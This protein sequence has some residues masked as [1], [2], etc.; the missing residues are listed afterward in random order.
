MISTIP[1]H[2]LDVINERDLELQVCGKNTPDLELL[3]RHTKYSGSLTIDSGL[4]K[5]FWNTLENFRE[6]DKL[7]FIKFC[8]CQERLPANDEEFIRRNT[9][10]MIK[11]EIEHKDNPDNALPH[12]D[13]CFFNL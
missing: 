13:T 1:S 9:R 2:Y 8:W 7:R 4:I 5:M 10:F 3:K 11:P 12:A 6:D